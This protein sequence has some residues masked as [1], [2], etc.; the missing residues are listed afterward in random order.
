MTITGICAS[1]QQNMTHPSKRGEDKRK[2][3]VKTGRKDGNDGVNLIKALA[4]SWEG[5][6]DGA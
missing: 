3:M 2:G 4:R 6:G 5:G 1:V